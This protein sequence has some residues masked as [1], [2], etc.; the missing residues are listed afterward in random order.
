MLCCLCLLLPAAA[1]ADW[2]RFTQ[3]GNTERT[4]LTLVTDLPAAQARAL[5]AQLNGFDAV[6]RHFIPGPVDQT[7]PEL[8]LV[9][10][11]RRA[12]FEKV[13]NQRHFAAYTQPEIASTT[14]VVGPE[15][16]HN[17]VENTLHEYVHYRLRTQP[18]AFPRWYEEGLAV[19]LSAA[20]LD[21]Q[22][23]QARVGHRLPAQMLLVN[24]ALPTMKRL[25]TPIHT[26][27]WPKS[28]LPG[29]YKHSAYLVRYLWLA[30][31]TDQISRRQAA[32]QAHLADR[33]Q[34]L[35][36]LLQVSHTELTR[37]VR[38]F[39]HSSITPITIDVPEQG[40]TQLEIEPLSQ[41]ELLELKAQTAELPNPGY[42][43]A[44]YRR[45]TRAYPGEAAYWAAL[46][47]SYS[48]S[49]RAA[50]KADRALA[51]AVRLQPDHPE[52][53]VQQAAA[54]VRNCPLDPSLRCLPAWRA[55]STP[56]RRALQSNP[57][58]FRAILWL[59]TLELYAGNPGSALNYLRIAHSR[60]PWSPRVNYHLGE[61]LRLVGN[62]RA[63]QHLQQAIW[64]SQDPDLRSLASAA[65]DLMR[66]QNRS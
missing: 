23:Q 15:D 46:A 10:F 17:V 9:V 18:I 47:R 35:P 8:R 61:C 41:R 19:M 62:P 64:W 39:N 45:L 20:E 3:S 60:A 5:V 43:A 36:E 30:G 16:D 65:L 51:E 66:N 25:L 28:R 31:G 52:V 21:A 37:Q 48:F 29:F 6:T 27:P 14:L 1:L 13:V 38:Q 55:A 63:A 2:Q 4:G 53:L 54:M 32:L 22:R 42:A 44:V 56:L 50:G 33:D 40:E 57:S 26:K 7:L 34:A 49:S 12:M 24:P 58:H 11:A 59:G